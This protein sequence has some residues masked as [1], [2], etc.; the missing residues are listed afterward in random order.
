[1]Y[2]LICNYPGSQEHKRGGK[3]MTMKN[4]KKTTPPETINI[5]NN[6][7]SVTQESIIKDARKFKLEAEATALVESFKQ[8]LAANK[9]AVA[10]I[11][12]YIF[13]VNDFVEFIE[14]IEKQ[15]FTGSFTDSHYHNYIK[16]QTESN[17]KI[18]TLK[19]R[20]NSISSFNNFLIEKKFM[21]KNVVNLKSGEATSVQDNINLSDNNSNFPQK[22]EKI[23]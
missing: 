11:K 21:L 2:I 6:P 18:K 5:S 8:Q 4:S 16:S 7:I 20:I 1:M 10:T 3:N 9:K 23:V 13:D 22:L 15:K 12:S 14:T 19:K 17:Y